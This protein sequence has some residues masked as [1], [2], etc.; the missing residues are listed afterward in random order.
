MYGTITTCLI[1]SSVLGSEICKMSRLLSGF[2][3]SLLP[4]L[5]CHTVYHE[6]KLHRGSEGSEGALKLL[7]LF[8]SE[9][10]FEV[11]LLVAHIYCPLF[12]AME[13]FQSS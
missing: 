13:Q 4:V 1:S 2:L 5:P 8:G 10:S 6:L 7:F 3:L 9:C 11:N 12:C